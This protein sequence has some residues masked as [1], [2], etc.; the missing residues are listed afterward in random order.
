VNPRLGK[1]HRYCAE[2]ACARA[3]RAAAQKKW[4]SKNGG[5]AYFT[6]EVHADRVRRWR[7]HHPRYWQKEHPAKLTLP[8]ET[9]L[10][11]K[12][13]AALRYVALQETIDTRFALEIGLFL[14]TRALRYKTR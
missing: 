9:T 7:E 1:R 13:S 14:I 8:P 12:L 5:K 3:S 10:P 11:K 2:P 6:G 4:L